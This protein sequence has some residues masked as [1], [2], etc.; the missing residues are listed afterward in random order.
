MK[1]VPQCI[2]LIRNVSNPFHEFAFFLMDDDDNNTLILPNRKAAED[3][4]KEHDFG[5]FAYSIIEIGELTY[6]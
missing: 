5:A 1:K 4:I 6:E 3:A 2:V